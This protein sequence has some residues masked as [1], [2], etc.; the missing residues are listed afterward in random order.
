MKTQV[1]LIGSSVVFFSYNP[2][3]PVALFLRSVPSAL[4][5]IDNAPSA[6]Y[7]AFSQIDNTAGLPAPF[8][9]ALFA[10]I[11]DAVGANYV[12]IPT[13]IAA[14]TPAAGGGGGTVTAPDI[15]TYDMQYDQIAGGFVRVLTT[16]DPVTNVPTRRFFSV[17]GVPYTPTDAGQVLQIDARFTLGTQYTI[18]DIERRL[19]N[20]MTAA[21]II[22]N[23]PSTDAQ[24]A[25]TFNQVIVEAPL[26][27][28]D[29]AFNT[30]AGAQ[31]VQIVA[32]S[33]TFT[34][35]GISGAITYPLATAGG[36]LIAS[37]NLEAPFSKTL[38]AITFTIVDGSSVL[39]TQLLPTL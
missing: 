28:G 38:P 5:T 9:T 15:A 7:V 6:G 2:V 36:G 18:L 10:D 23:N 35:D 24:P 19:G 31:Q 1:Y 12:S 39:L 29:I 26:G 33:G 14:I 34:M 20:I 13:M 3:G 37:F 22:D 16:F 11:V 27:G 32:L 21:G 30:A 4:L 17:A 25:M 8:L